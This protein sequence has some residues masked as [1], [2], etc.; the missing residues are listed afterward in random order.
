MIIDLHR[1]NTCRSTS[2]YQVTDFQGKKA[3][4][5]CNDPIYRIDHLTAV[6]RLHGLTIDV[7]PEIEIL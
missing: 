1:T 7:E 6:A 3:T 5:K 4:D 2:K